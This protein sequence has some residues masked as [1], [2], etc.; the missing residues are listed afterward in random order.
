MIQEL[1]VGKSYEIQTKNFHR[2]FVGKIIDLSK[3]RILVE[4]EQLSLIDS[5]NFAV[6]AQ[7]EVE[8]LDIKR[9]LEDDY[10]FS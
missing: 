8:R 7:V 4:I 1:V 10:F 5:E 6:H 2:S 3:E 9:Q